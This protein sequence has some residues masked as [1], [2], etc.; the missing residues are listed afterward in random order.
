MGAF[1]LAWPGLDLP[2][3]LGA[4]RF[5][6]LALSFLISVIAQ[7]QIHTFSVS[8]RSGLISFWLP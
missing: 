1:L 8:C 3:D 4:S 5:M 6:S 7:S 2:P